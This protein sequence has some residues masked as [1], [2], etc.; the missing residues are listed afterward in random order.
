MDDGTSTLKSWE[1]GRWGGG[2]GGFE[3]TA[4][5][6]RYCWS[7][8]LFLFFFYAIEAIQRS[9]FFLPTV[10]PPRMYFILQGSFSSSFS[11]SFPRPLFGSS[12]SLN[13]L[14]F[15]VLSRSPPKQ[16]LK[17]S[18]LKTLCYP[19]HVCHFR[20]IMSSHNVFSAEPRFTLFLVQF[21]M[22]MLKRRL[23][24]ESRARATADS[25]ILEVSCADR[26]E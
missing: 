13:R 24:D 19:R 16:C 9:F 12:P 20:F 14:P 17:I 10:I 6:T 15:V 23:E 25:R 26:I 11:R 22:E 18:M 2:K 1:W 7:S 8:P 3:L 4:S 5:R 21:E